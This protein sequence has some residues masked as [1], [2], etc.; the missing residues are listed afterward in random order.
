[1]NQNESP[2]KNR[3]KTFDPLTSLIALGAN[4][5]DGAEYNKT[6]RKELGPWFDLYPYV[7]PDETGKIP[8]NSGALIG[9]KSGWTYCTSHVIGGKLVGI[10]GHNIPA[11]LITT[12]DIIIPMIRD[13]NSKIWMS[14]TPM[15]M[16]TQRFGI[17]K[18][19][20]RVL[21]AGCGLGWFARQCLVKKGVKKVTV[22][23]NNLDILRKFGANL[24]REFGA[25]VLC[26][27]ADA[28]EYTLANLDKFD[29]VLFDIWMGW[30]E[31][32]YDKQFEKL[33]KACKKAGV[34]CWGWGYD[35]NE[36]PELF[37]RRS[38]EPA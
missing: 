4:L 35:V 17:A 5:I 27:H 15:E 23:D 31:A 16:I 38:N 29:V 12:E 22:V 33:L 18:A 13:E 34:E 36:V 21:V 9:G 20:G 32:S 28:Y 10:L 8:D 6:V 26:K 24:R 14:M 19:K 1:M 30:G 11:Y 25:K 7:M 3:V 2:G 37:E